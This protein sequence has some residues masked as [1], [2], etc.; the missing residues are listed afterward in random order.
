MNSSLLILITPSKPILDFL[1]LVVADLSKALDP[2]FLNELYL[3]RLLKD[4]FY[5]IF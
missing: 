1:L 5:Y 4:I 2:Y 3:D